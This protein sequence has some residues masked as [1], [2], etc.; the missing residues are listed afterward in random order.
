MN[1]LNVKKLAATLTVVCSLAPFAAMLPQSA[2][3]V[4]ISLD[5]T[6]G[7]SG[8]INSA[9]FVTVDRQS[10]GTGVIQSFVRIQQNGTEEGYNAS[11]RPVMS[12]VNTSPTFT[13]DVQVME[14]PVVIDPYTGLVGSYYEFLLDINESNGGNNPLISLDSLQIYTRSSALVTAN[15]LGALTGS[16]TLRYNL[17]AGDS[18]NEVLLDYS[19]N[20]GSGSGDLLVYVPTSLFAGVTGTD[21]LYLYSKFG[22]K[23]GGYS[24]SAGFEEW[25]YIE[26]EKPTTQVPDSAST[27]LLI[28]LGL[29]SVGFVARRRKS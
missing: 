5:L 26:R 24:S 29:A 10:T 25:A 28:G 11:A 1:L 16:S 23:G 13:R 12:N 14:I 8:V 19:L 6:S 17:D 15:T 22:S 9:G 2:L 27:L 7:G 21:F 18:G 4:P 20:S 3:A